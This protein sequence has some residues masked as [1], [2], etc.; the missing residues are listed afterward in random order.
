MEQA[1]SC[2]HEYLLQ[3][4][5][6]DSPQFDLDACLARTVGSELPRLQIWMEERVVAGAAQRGTRIVPICPLSD[7][8]DP[9]KPQFAISSVEIA[10]V[11]L[12][13]LA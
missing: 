6:S 2:S 7:L 13:V 9:N 11:T 3:L 1:T 8:Y 10:E 12:N 5:V 4:P